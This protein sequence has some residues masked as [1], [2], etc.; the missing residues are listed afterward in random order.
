MNVE[1]A[2]SIRHTLPQE[3]THYSIKEKIVEGWL[4]RITLGV[5]IEYPP[6]FQDA[7][8]KAIKADKFPIIIANHGSLSGAFGLARLAEDFT[9]LANDVL[10]QDQQIKGFLLPLA[11]TVANGSMGKDIQEFYEI[12]K[13]IIEARR[14][15][16]VHITRTKDVK[17]GE[18]WNFREFYSNMHN[19]IQNGYGGIALFPEGTVESSRRDKAGNRKGMQPLQEGVIATM[20]ELAGIRKGHE[21]AI[22]AV[23][24]KGDE[25]IFDPAL[26]RPHLPI[27]PVGFFFPEGIMKV[28]VG[29]I[30][31]ST[32]PEV[33]EFFKS[34]KDRKNKEQ[35]N[36][37]FGRKIAELLSQE[38]RGVYA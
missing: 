16:P 29:N 8:Q 36:S 11:T 37:F 28:T 10:P 3:K 38:Q 30:T 18:T 23:G 9:T 17:N 35:L 31:L 7:Y 12:S 15:I 32:D 34:I 1:Q 2:G 27:I 21:I 26:N 5:K 20:A 6:E 22:I 25:K 19:G 14:L 33:S 13:P 24:I 4:E